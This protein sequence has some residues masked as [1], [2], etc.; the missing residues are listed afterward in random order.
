MKRLNEKKR[1]LW[2]G[3]I[4]LVLAVVGS[5]IF[6]IPG[7]ANGAVGDKTNDPTQYN[8]GGGD[9]VPP[10]ST[11]S[12]SSGGGGD[13]ITTVVKSITQI[14][15]FMVFPVGTISEALF[16]VFNKS[17]VSSG[18]WAVQQETN[19]LPCSGIYFPPRL[20]EYTIR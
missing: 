15:H 9:P 2:I 8:V 3:C 12:G 11:P 14:F 1:I 20:R 5:S 4:A 16:D 17:L 18:T 19:G 7:F 10:P 6:S 13:V